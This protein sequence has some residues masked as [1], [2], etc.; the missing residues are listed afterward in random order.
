ML[1]LRN[2]NLTFAQRQGYPCAAVNKFGCYK[3]TKLLAIFQLLR[4]E[5][6]LLRTLFTGFIFAEGKRLRSLSKAEQA[7]L[8]A[9]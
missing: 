8:A 7:L 2:S 1:P 9:S 5:I 4:R 3:V 6:I